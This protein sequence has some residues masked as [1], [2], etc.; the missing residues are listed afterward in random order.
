MFNRPQFERETTRTESWQ[1]PKRSGDSLVYI[2]LGS[3]LGDRLQNLTF[4]LEAL[5]QTSGIIF[6]K[7]SAIYETAPVDL[8]PDEPDPHSFYNA[9]IAVRS[10]LAPEALMQACLTVEDHAGRKR[11][12]KPACP[13]LSYYSRILD[14]DILLIGNFIQKTPALTVPHPRFH[15]RAFVLLPFCDI[16]PDARHPEKDCTVRDLLE[17]LPPETVAQCQKLPP[18]APWRS[19]QAG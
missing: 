18:V 8:S 15:E 9:V 2:A 6:E 1:L 7:A 11:G 16:A 4:A 17:L 14:L 5:K 19:Y 12:A 10:N 13:D 3:N